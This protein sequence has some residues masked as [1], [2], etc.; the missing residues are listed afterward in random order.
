MKSFYLRLTLQSDAVLTARSGSVGVMPSLERIPGSCLLG[1]AAASCYDSLSDDD[2]W[3]AFHSGQVRFGD[4]LP[5]GASGRAAVPVPLSF[6][7]R[8]GTSPEKA[9]DDGVE[10]LDGEAVRNAARG[11][12]EA[13]TEDAPVQWKQLRA[14]FVTSDLER[15]LLD[16]RGSMRSAM[17]KGGRAREG[18]LYGYDALRAGTV[19]VAR[20]DLDDEA[21]HLLETL[22]HALL[23]G[24]VLIGRSKGTEYGRTTV[25]EATPWT[26]AEREPAADRLV[27]YAISDLALRDAETGSP[28]LV[29]EASVLGLPEGLRLC[30]EASSLRTRRYTPFNGHRRRPDLERQ[31]IAA[32]SVLVFEGASGLDVDSLKQS[33]R[34]GVGDYRQDGLG[35]VV[36][37]PVMLAGD[38]PVQSDSTAQPVEADP[39]VGA[40]M[41]PGELA[42]WLQRERGRDLAAT[43]AFRRAREW[44]EEM[45]RWQPPLP[46]S[47][48]SVIRSTAL[49]ARNRKQL[50]D[51]L[52]D[53]KRGATRTGVGKLRERWGAER[54]GK[55]RWQKLEELIE[56]LDENHEVVC[57]ALEQ[58][59][60]R[61]VRQRREE[62][63]GRS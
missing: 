50:L 46:A 11:D 53:E 6:H 48:W 52:F 20:I 43:Q 31:V 61:M 51:D 22:K 54:G 8:K 59:A 57:A 33:L 28:T 62:R 24:R 29:P 63:E 45:A 41:P 1:A 26:L 12:L 36:V 60:Q 3:L 17:G 13:G 44:K 40:E 16:H 4:G 15:V 58:L 2:A 30:L 37:E 39:D 23:T 10:R 7:Y 14:G 21:A 32:G 9:D 5:L 27:V 55:K 38:G 42:A 47:Q 19:F 56:N 35:Q 18:F 25:E 49:R 34:S